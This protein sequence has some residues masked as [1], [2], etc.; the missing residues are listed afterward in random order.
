[1]RRMN[2]TTDAD[3]QFL[4]RVAVMHLPGRTFRV[5]PSTHGAK[6]ETVFRGVSVARLFSMVSGSGS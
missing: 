1:L 4:W 5:L 6:W 3:K 2:E